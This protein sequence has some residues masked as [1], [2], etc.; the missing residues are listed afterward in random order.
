MRWDLHTQNDLLEG[1]KGIRKSQ[2][3]LEWQLREM[4]FLVT[5]EPRLARL[6]NVT[7]PHL[8]LTLERIFE[9][10]TSMLKELEANAQPQG[11]I[12]RTTVRAPDI[13]GNLE[14]ISEHLLPEQGGPLNIPYQE[15]LHRQDQGE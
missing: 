5:F 12:W 14:R 2:C 6:L 4:R 13:C 8:R 7:E 3:L 1:I 10:D 15:E 9:E 11:C